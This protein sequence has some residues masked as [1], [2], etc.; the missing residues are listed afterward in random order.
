MSIEV[1]N[2]QSEDL[3]QENL[4]ELK[5]QLNKPWQMLYLRES[6]DKQYKIYKYELLQW[7]NKWWIK[8]KY[9]SQ[10]WPWV[11]WTQFTDAMWNKIDKD[12]F[13]AWE[14]VYLRVPKNAELNN[15][16]E[17]ENVPGKFKFIRNSMDKKNNSW[18]VY[19]YTFEY[20]WNLWW[21]MKKRRSQIWDEISEKN[22][23]DEN[24]NRLREYWFEKWETVYIKVPDWEIMDKIPEMT[25]DEIM[26]LSD[27]DLNRVFDNLCSPYS[28][29]PQNFQF[30]TE[31]WITTP[32][33]IINN[34]KIYWDYGE[35]EK[36]R[37]YINIEV[38]EADYNVYNFAIYKKVW[39]TLRWVFF[40]G[41][42]VYRWELVDGSK[43]NYWAV[44][45][46]DYY[47][48]SGN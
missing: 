9:I 22:F 45:P 32:Y 38:H 4:L 40:D 30:D 42:E 28:E 2:K 6:T 36:N 48:F 11:E 33:Y 27:D 47:I 29:I 43:I 12:R 35:I 1:K 17:T 26:A 41:E 14:V 18:K 8:N 13:S 19:K 44:Y 7:G 39:N 34:R 46:K 31:S 23:C 24:G 3:V 25:L 5:N 10:I 37:A 16:K 20:W 15:W 21:V